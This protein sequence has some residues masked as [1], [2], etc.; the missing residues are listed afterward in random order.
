[1]IILVVPKNFFD[2]TIHNLILDLTI[3]SENLRL[4]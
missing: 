2:H 4:G 3:W 1:M